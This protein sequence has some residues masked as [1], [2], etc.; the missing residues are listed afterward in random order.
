MFVKDSQATR[1]EKKT[2]FSIIAFLC[3][4]SVYITSTSKVTLPVM[5][6]WVAICT[7]AVF[8]ASIQ[9]AYL[10]YYQ[11][12]ISYDS[13]LALLA[14]GYMATSLLAI[15]WM[16]FLPNTLYNTNAWEQDSQTSIWIWLIWHALFPLFI[17]L[18]SLQNS[19]KLRLSYPL[20]QWIFRTSPLIIILMVF[21]IIYNIDLLPIVGI[22]NKHLSIEFDVTALILSIFAIFSL[23]S[24]DGNF[25][26]QNLWLLLA[27][28]VH[29]LDIL[30]VIQGEERYSTGWYLGMMNSVIASSIILGVFIR[31]IIVVAKEATEANKNLNMLVETDALSG[32]ANRRKFDTIFKT[33]WTLAFQQKGS[34][35]LI[36]LDVDHFKQFNDHFGH[37]AGDQCLKDIAKAIKTV[38]KR[39]MDLVA[40]IGGEEFAIVMYGIKEKVAFEIA[41]EA[42]KS[43]ENLR[44]PSPLLKGKSV[45][46][47]AGYA[48]FMPQSLEASHELMEMADQALY[49]AKNKGRNRV[50]SLKTVAKNNNPASR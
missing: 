14:S 16:I 47:S 17:I 43:V 8:V 39:E 5:P 2:V 22:G 1:I 28:V 19:G 20:S 25:R 48:I 15:G 49:E 13:S 31:H 36:L 27:A 38:T 34:I 30:Y 29:A 42:R 37:P 41:E 45:T 33:L 21:A 4:L 7:I 50:V 18:Y 26:R 6:S 11:S 3:L 9:T 10:L 40:R 46:I 35:C 12:K 24:W 23:I 44:I 32:L